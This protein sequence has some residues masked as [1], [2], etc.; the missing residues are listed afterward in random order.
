MT[1]YKAGYYATPQSIKA[2]LAKY[3][4]KKKNSGVHVRQWGLNRQELSI[5]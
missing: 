4:E 5:R 2:A 1:L 3:F